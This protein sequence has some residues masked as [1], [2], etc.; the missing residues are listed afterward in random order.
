MCSEALVCNGHFSLQKSVRFRVRPV[1]A[2]FKEDY[3]QCVS[4]HFFRL[5][6][7]A[8]PLY[9]SEIRRNRLDLSPQ[10]F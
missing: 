9:S 5:S 6:R 2:V 4:G 3:G 1:T 7:Q 8:A 10:S